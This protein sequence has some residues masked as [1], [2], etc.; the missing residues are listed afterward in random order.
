MP[1]AGTV[2]AAGAAQTL[3]VTFTPTNASSYSPATKTVSIAVS[4]ATPII[5]WPAP[6]AIESGTPLG[7]TQ[8]NATTSVAG[9]FVYSPVSGTILA[10]G[11]GQRLSV[12]FTPT[13]SANY[14]TASSQ[15]SMTVN[16]ATQSGGNTA[17]RANSYDDAWQAG[18]DGWIANAQ[19]ILAGG[20]NQTA[21]LVLWIGDAL[22]L[23][24][25]LG[26]W[27]QRG[28]GKTA[29]DQAITNWMHAGLSPQG[30]NSIDG[31][32]LAASNTCPARS[33]TAGNALGAAD[34]M[35]SSMPPDTNPSTARLKLQ[36]CATYPKALNLFTMLAALPAAQFAIPQLNFAVGNPGVFTDLE[37]M[38]DLMIANHVVP[39]I[40]T[41]T[42]GADALANTQVDSYNTALIQYARSKKLPLI[43][44]NRE[45][46]ARLPLAQWP[47]R[48]LAGGA[49][50]TSGTTQFPS[51]SDP[52]ASGG[53]PATHTTGLALTYDGYGLKGWLGVQKMKEIKQFVIDGAMTTLSSVATSS[54]T[55]SSA[56]ITWTTNVAASSRADYGTTSAYGASAADASLAVGHSLSLTGLAASTLYHY[57]VTSQASTG[58]PASSADLVFTTAAPAL[59][60]TNTGASNVTGSSATVSWTTN[61]ASS[62]RVAFGPTTAYGASAVNAA[63]VTAHGLTLTGLSPATTYHY[64]VTS[65]GAAGGPLSS[66]DFTLRTLSASD[67]TA[68]TVTSATPA[69]GSSGV[70]STTTVNATFSEAMNAATI[71]DGVVCAAQSGQRHRGCRR[72]LQPDHRS[73]HVDANDSTHG[74]DGLYGDDRRRSHGCERRGR[75]R[76]GGQFR[77]VVHDR[78]RHGTG[79]QHLERRGHAGSV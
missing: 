19:A 21:G 26:A 16:A 49:L 53:D 18:A 52:Y 51:T 1:A 43:D 35:G 20:T 14:N 75:Q 63:M 48:F 60:I 27:A 79:A 66:G 68:P 30:I 41:Y 32:A 42:Y 55:S 78:S 39:I 57:K 24:P 9:T 17:A 31:F 36:D 46:L 62:S 2:L 25:A 22:T 59:T 67:T 73:R 5:T 61:V 45:M 15:V 23:N 71:T 38:A 74:S 54:V 44:L 3:S 4:K 72:D 50:Y 37:Q 11:T 47:G 40:V 6:A 28:A 69:A 12:A 77:P 76:A 8:L 64:V 65:Q 33:Y 7:A 34:F 58:M 10:D 56:T 13:T 29:E 70:S